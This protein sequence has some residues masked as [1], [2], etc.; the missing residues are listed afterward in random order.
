MGRKATFYLL[1]RLF[2][3]FTAAA[4]AVTLWCRLAAADPD[5]AVCRR[6]FAGV[7]GCGLFFL[8]AGLTLWWLVR[9]RWITALLPLAALVVG[10]PDWS[11]L[12]RMPRFGACPEGDLRIATLNVHGFQGAPTRGISARE[13]AAMLR[14]ECVDVVCLQEVADDAE[15][16][17]DELAAPFA[18]DYPYHVRR[19]EQAVFSRFPIDSSEYVRF[20]GS[21][22]SCMRVDLTVEGRPV[23]VISAHFQT[24]GVPE[25][26]R[27]FRRDYGRRLPADSLCS[28]LERNAVLRSRQA[29][30]V[31]RMAEAA[32]RAT[33]VVGDFNEI[34]ASHT[35]E[36]VGEGFTDAFLEC[37]HG[38]GA[39]FGG[40]L[41]ID[42]I[43]FDGEF[44]GV[45][46]HVVRTRDLSDHRPVVAELRF[47]RP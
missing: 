18:D 41:R 30:L 40:I 19:E 37:G 6:L 23:R 24:S 14:G 44:A 28:V 3:L 36:T 47:V 33:I 34:S 12:V 20:E 17:F 16:P 9:R 7:G 27:R 13:T 32:S 5:G 35:Y 25:A 21:N 8:N 38:W 1:G 39:T 31:R 29:A 10:A 46:C 22:Q 45:D 2:I 11:G 42:Y 4:F 26:A 43:L 15:H